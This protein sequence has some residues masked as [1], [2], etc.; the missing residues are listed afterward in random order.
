MTSF[1]AVASEVG[2]AKSRVMDDSEGS[3]LAR[4]TS[5]PLGGQAGVDGTGDLA[6]AAGDEDGH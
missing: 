4:R 1:N 3:R 6:A 5:R 2:S